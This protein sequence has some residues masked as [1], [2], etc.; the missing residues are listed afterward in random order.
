VYAL[1]GPAGS[2]KSALVKELRSQGVPMLV[3]HTTRPAKPGEQDGVDYYFVDN[4]QFA[5]ARPFERIHYNG[6]QF[7]LTKEEVSRKMNEYQACTVDIDR[8]GFDQLKKLIGD[9]LESIFILVDKETIFS[10]FMM[11]GE[12]LETVK[13]RI[14]LAEANGEYDNWQI[15]DHVVK[16]TGSVARAVLQIL[17]IMGKVR[18]TD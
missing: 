6:H 5:Q 14:D 15:A 18:P 3:S 7:G 4:D 13:A 11:N 1:I 16:N 10:R 2:G 8:S 9:R 17:A 12:K